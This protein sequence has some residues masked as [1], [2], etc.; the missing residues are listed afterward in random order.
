M[1]FS[2]NPGVTRDSWVTPGLPLDSK[3]GQKCQRFQR[4]THDI[5]GVVIVLYVLCACVS[6]PAAWR[7]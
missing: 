5:F 4:Y 7:C 2:L 1:L 3:T 6:V